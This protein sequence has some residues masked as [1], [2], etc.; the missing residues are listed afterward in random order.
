MKKVKEFVQLS[1]KK[2]MKHIAVTW[3]RVQ[4]VKY[5]ELYRYTQE[6]K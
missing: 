1:A 4:G 2:G 5:Y 3:K 6:S